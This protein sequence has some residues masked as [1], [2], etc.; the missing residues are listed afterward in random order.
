M[1][2]VRSL[3]AR[4][5]D[6]RPCRHPAV[7]PFPSSLNTVLSIIPEC[8]PFRHPRMVLSGIDHISWIPARRRRE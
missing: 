5:R 7:P 6:G 2:V 1:T 8:R 4:F 3:D